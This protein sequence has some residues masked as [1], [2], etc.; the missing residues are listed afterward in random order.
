VTGTKT[1]AGLV[2]AVKQKAA[3]GKIRQR[4]AKTTKRR[5]PIHLSQS[6]SL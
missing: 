2:I 5:I 6:F 3:A 4:P 1:T